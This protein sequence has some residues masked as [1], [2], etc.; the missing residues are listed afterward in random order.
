MANLKLLND[1]NKL[2]FKLGHVYRKKLNIIP[3]PGSGSD[4][5]GFFYLP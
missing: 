5:K 4:P 3:P 1:N 2:I